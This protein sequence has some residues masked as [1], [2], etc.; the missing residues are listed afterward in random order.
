MRY[1]GK[2]YGRVGNKYF[3]TGKTSDD[4]DNLQPKI[5]KKISCENCDDTGK[6]ELVGGEIIGCE[7]CGK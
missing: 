2:L 4:W 1:K 7:W 6:T 5:I 3:D